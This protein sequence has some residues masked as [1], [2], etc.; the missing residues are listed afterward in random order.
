MLNY[1]EH[2]AKKFQRG[3]LVP[4]CGRT[5][6]P[7]TTRNGVRVLYCYHTGNGNHYYV[8]LDTDTIMEDDE[9]KR[10]GLL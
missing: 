5:E 6:T 9:L 1:E 3:Q 8:N 2:Q 7:F 4:A 10:E